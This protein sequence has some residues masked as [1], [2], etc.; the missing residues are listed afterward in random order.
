[1]VALNH[2]HT[3]MFAILGGRSE[4][5]SLL[6]AALSERVVLRE[7]RHAQQG[8]N[9]RWFKDKAELSAQELEE[10][11]KTLLFELESISSNLKTAKD[12]KDV[13]I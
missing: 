6:G 8:G 3:A 4:G 11:T 9:S 2:Q 10:E 13:L 1:M 5:G 12:L 7:N